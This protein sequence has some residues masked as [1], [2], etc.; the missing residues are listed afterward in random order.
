MKYLEN[1]SLF[2]FL[3]SMFVRENVSKK[4]DLRNL[5]VYKLRFILLFFINLLFKFVRL[6]FISSFLK[7]CF[8]VYILIFYCYTAEMK[9]KIRKC[10]CSCKGL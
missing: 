8:F 4:T 3:V 5:R 2:N 9:D 6:I 7:I 10:S 1:E